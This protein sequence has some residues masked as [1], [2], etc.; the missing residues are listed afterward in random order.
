M[1]GFGALTVDNG[2]TG[3][4]LP[5]L[6]LPGCKVK[7]MMQTLQG[8][9]IIPQ[10]EIGMRRAFGRQVLGQRL[11]LAAGRK[12]IENCVQDFPNIHLAPPSATFS[13]RDQRRH[14]RPFGIAQ[15]T[16][17][18]KTTAFSRT[19]MFRLP[20]QAPSKN[21]SGANQGI[22]TDSTDSRTFGIGSEN[23][24]PTRFIGAGLANL[25]TGAREFSPSA[26]R[27]P[28]GLW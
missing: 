21:E 26:Q 2:N 25:L 15:I 1:S 20:H 14:Q 22:T 23:F 18:T 24:R 28:V 16:R 12:H 11:P 7:C 9:V 4:C 3:A 6:V 27:N 17:I 8:T 5:S 10:H 19:T 13:R